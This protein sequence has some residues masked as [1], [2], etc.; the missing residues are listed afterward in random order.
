MSMPSSSERRARYL[1]ASRWPLMRK[2]VS[3]PSFHTLARTCASPWEEPTRGRQAVVDAWLAHKD[4]PGSWQAS[5]EPVAL[6]GDVAVTRGVSRYFEADGPPKRTYHN[7][8]ILRFDAWGR[9]SSY[10]D[11]FMPEPQPDTTSESEG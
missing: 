2:V 1:A 4:P 11:W 5:W 7:V 9:C 3:A 10:T 8:W 6:E